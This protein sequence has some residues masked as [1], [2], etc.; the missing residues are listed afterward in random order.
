MFKHK[1]FQF[2]IFVTL[3]KLTLFKLQLK[4]KYILGQKLIYEYLYWRD[5]L[6]YASND[7]YVIPYVNENYFSLLYAN[8]F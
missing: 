7:I 6:F 1:N 5:F 2:K 8:L 4:Y 3:V